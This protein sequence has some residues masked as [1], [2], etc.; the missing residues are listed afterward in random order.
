MAENTMS[1][2]LEKIWCLPKAET[3]IQDEKSGCQRGFQK[4]K[5]PPLAPHVGSIRRG[6]EG[7]S[8]WHAY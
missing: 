3:D 1:P 2:P 8:S 5:Q 4:H 7:H 6:S